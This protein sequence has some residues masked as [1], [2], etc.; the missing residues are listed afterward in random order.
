MIISSCIG[1]TMLQMGHF[2]AIIYHNN[3]GTL[4][5]PSPLTRRPR[6]CHPDRS[7]EQSRTSSPTNRNAPA[8]TDTMGF[9]SPGL[10][11]III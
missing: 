2:R 4:T 11:A 7:P 1:R 3:D 8:M 6:I 5:S 10:I 9:R